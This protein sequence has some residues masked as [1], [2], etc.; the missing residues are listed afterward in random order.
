MSLPHPAPLNDNAKFPTTVQ[1]VLMLRAGTHGE[2]F[3]D[4]RKHTVNFWPVNTHF[5]I[6]VSIVHRAFA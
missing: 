1:Y 2:I 4:T 6:H 5:C 3:L